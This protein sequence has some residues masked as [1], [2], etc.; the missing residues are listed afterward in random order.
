MTERRT[1][2]R[3]VRTPAELQSQNSALDKER[4]GR[5]YRIASGYWKGNGSINAADIAQTALL[6]MYSRGAV[7]SGAPGAFDA[8]VVQNTIRDTL[9]KPEIKL[10][11]VP[12]GDSNDPILENGGSTDNTVNVGQREALYAALATLSP[13][14]RAVAILRGMYDLPVADVS[15]LLDMPPGTVKNSFHRAL[16]KLRGEM[17]EDGTETE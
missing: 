8:Q 13:Q 14:L 17:G 16:R 9:R 7:V 12:S 5:V 3:R 10:N 4:V 2:I 1:V 15:R 11:A 6:N